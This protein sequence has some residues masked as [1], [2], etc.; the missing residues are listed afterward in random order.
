MT[1]RS[2]RT[3]RYPRRRA[4][5][6]AASMALRRLPITDAVARTAR[7]SD[8]LSVSGHIPRSPARNRSRTAAGYASSP[9]NRRSASIASEN[10]LA[11]NNHRERRRDV[12]HFRTDD[13][14][15]HDAPAQRAYRARG[16]GGRGFTGAHDADP[17]A[18]LDSCAVL[19]RPHDETFGLDAFE[20]G[21]DDSFYVAPKP[22]R[23]RHGRL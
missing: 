11:A 17:V 3:T 7:G 5:S 12:D 4:A 23:I 16:H 6:D 1:G 2:I 13:E 10:R 19:E 14:A 8:G 21:T 18:G 20:A 9:P 22:Q 15:A